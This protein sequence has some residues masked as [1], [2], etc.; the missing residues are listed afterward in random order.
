MRSRYCTTDIND[1]GEDDED[2]ETAKTRERFNLPDCGCGG[3]ADGGKSFR[4]DVHVCVYT[5]RAP[6]FLRRGSTRLVNN[7][8]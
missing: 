6:G 5:R 2:D 1:D 7:R 8:N 4:D 3:L